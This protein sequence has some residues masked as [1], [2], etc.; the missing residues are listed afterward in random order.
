MRRLIVAA[1]LLLVS[2]AACF[3]HPEMTKSDARAFTTK[4]LQHVGLSGVRVAETVEAASYKSADPRFIRDQAVKVWATS[5]DVD[6]GTVLLDVERRGDRAVY[7]RDTR[8]D[9]GGPLLTDQQFSSLNRFR[10]DPAGDRHRHRARPW[11]ATAVVLIVLVGGA[12]FA[13][14][15]GRGRE[16]A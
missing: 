13:V 8:A 12:M 9:G 5:A 1:G 6:G 7:V 14:A 10:Y 3:A 16:L 4:A 11:A 2:T 15:L